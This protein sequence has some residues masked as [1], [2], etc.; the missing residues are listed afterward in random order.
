MNL[1]AKFEYTLLVDTVKRQWKILFDAYRK[2]H[3]R[4]RVQAKSGA[5]G[6]KVS[7][8]KFYNELNFPKDIVTNRVTTTD[9][10]MP[11]SD[12]NPIKRQLYKMFKHTQTIRRL[13]P[14]NFLRV[15]DHFVGLALKRL[16]LAHHQVLR[17]SVFNSKCL[18]HAIHLFNNPVKSSFNRPPIIT[19]L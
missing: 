14:T 2:A 6:S 3:Y 12:L 15:F 4:E 9:L 11:E 8:C 17:L 7:T 13:L 1:I 19:N 16:I 18:L 10:A 5:P